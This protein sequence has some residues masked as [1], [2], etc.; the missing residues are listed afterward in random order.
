MPAP[1]K[2]RTP[3]APRSARAGRRVTPS[4]RNAPTAVAAS[5]AGSAGRAAATPAPPHAPQPAHEIELKL[6]LSPD[7]AHRLAALPV[8]KTALRGRALTRTVHSVYYDTP[9]FALERA[10]IALRLRKQGSSWTQTIKTAGSVEAG[11]HQRQEFDTPLPA[12]VLNHTALVAAG[13][14]PIFTDPEVRHA[15]RPVF[16]TDFRRTTRNLAL[17]RGA[18]VELAYDRG[19]IT[20][21]DVG[22]AI[23]E[24]ELELKSGEPLELIEFAQAVALAL[25]VRLEPLSKAQRGYALAAQT[26]AAP[27]KAAVPA[28]RADMTVTEA[29]HSVVL[30][31][32][33]HLQA[34][35]TGVLDGVDPEYLHQARV[36]IRRL[37]SGLSVFSRAFPKAALLP[38]IQELRWL[39]GALGPARDWDVLATETLP[40]LAAAWPGD[41]GLHLLMERTAERREDAG[42]AARDALGAPRAAALLLDL[43]AVFYRAPWLALDD[44]AA[45]QQREAPLPAFA[46]QI[47]ARRHRKVIKLGRARDPADAAALHRLRIEIKKLRYA[48]EFFSPLWDR[49]AVRAYTPGLAALQEVLGSVNDAATA[50]R[51]CDAL[52]ESGQEPAWAEALGLLRGWAAASARGQLERFDEAWKAF[53]RSEPFWD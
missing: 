39:G 28:L 53:R 35:E 16:V 24:V 22:A 40:V 3:H 34:N 7:T 17:P 29:F 44:L 33:A 2:P 4:A 23:C 10:H 52:R 14:S 50:E 30:S 13:A 46:A 25:P 37:R 36:A 42:R 21:G 38:Q 27:V 18:Q 11:L 5:G 26:P 1:G 47:L 43:V 20:A 19:G 31:C 41:P 45:A 6:S 15:L 51:L 49:K 48:A 9:D 32:I 8:V 12:Q